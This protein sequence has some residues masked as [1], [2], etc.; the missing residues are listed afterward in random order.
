VIISQ[1]LLGTRE[2]VVIHHTDCG[3]L[4]F[5]NDDVVFWVKWLMIASIENQ[6]RIGRKVDC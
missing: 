5:S 2:I 1:Q 3:M 6:K 4:T